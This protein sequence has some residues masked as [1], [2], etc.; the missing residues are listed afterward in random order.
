MIGIIT[1][2]IPCPAGDNG[3][4]IWCSNEAYQDPNNTIPGF[5]WYEDGDTNFVSV[6]FDAYK[7]WYTW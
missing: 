2:L 4:V 5:S 6:I 7:R 3:Y 1:I